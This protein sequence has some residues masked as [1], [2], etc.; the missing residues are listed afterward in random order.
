VQRGE[1]T[2]VFF[3]W[4]IIYHI[5]HWDLAKIISLLP[6]SHAPWFPEFNPQLVYYSSEMGVES[7]LKRL[8]M[9]SS[10]P[11]SREQLMDKKK[12]AESIEIS[13]ALLTTRRTINI[14]P[15]YVA[16]EQVVL[17]TS[18]PYSHRI[19]LADGI[20]TD[21]VYIFQNKNY[22]ILPWT[23]PD[24]QEIAKINYFLKIRQELQRNL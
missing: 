12:Q 21:L 1:P 4:S 9:F 19:H 10:T 13:S 22:Q 18:K 7:S 11:A 14:D 3:F 15:G 24:Y 2:L 5:D 20:Y 16:L 8:F 6:H 23:Y 17:S